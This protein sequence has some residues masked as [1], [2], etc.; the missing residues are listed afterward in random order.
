MT[1]AIDGFPGWSIT[2]RVRIVLAFDLLVQS[3]LY[4]YCQ[5]KGYGSKVSSRNGQ[6]SINVPQDINH[7]DFRVSRSWD[8]VL[9]VEKVWQIWNCSES[10]CIPNYQNQF[11]QKLVIF[12][13]VW[14]SKNSRNDFWI[15][16]FRADWLSRRD[17]KVYSIFQNRAPWG[18]KA[19]YSNGSKVKMSVC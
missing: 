10:W 2:S 9:L 16:N 5:Q 12:F 17:E 19:F 15:R 13:V 3:C 4:H 1:Y 8:F 18:T 14:L 6:F 11:F 7:G